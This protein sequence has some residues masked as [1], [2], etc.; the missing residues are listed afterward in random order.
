MARKKTRTIRLQVFIHK[1][2]KKV[3]K[4]ISDPERLTRWFVDKATLSPHKGGRYSYSWED[5]PAH[6]GKVLEFVR[7][8]RL[9]LTWQWPGQEE[10]GVT[11]LKLSV[12]P[13]EDGTVLKFN[14]SGFGT[15]G[16]WVD[17]YDGAI[18]GWTY[19]LMNLKSVLEYGHDLRSPHDW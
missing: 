2:P 19:F 5:G 10:I 3:F 6:S 17:L 7:G 14:H 16:P 15:E 4:A 12:T 11:R 9:T 13:K 18:R 8:S 1:S